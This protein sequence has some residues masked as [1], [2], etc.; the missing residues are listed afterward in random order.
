M[1]DAR[2]YGVTNLA[3]D[4]LTVADN[5][6]RALASVPAEARELGDAAL[7]ALIE[8]VELTERELQAALGRSGVTRLAPQ[9][10]KN[11]TPTSIRRCYEAPDPTRACG[12]GD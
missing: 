7:K 1:T 5:L 11:S 9:G 8:G 6:A 12:H 2:A 4:L 3:R 10:A